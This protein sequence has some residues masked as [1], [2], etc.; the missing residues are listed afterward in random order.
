MKFGG[1]EIGCNHSK[2]PQWG[3]EQGIYVEIK[4]IRLPTHMGGGVGRGLASG[5]AA[6]SSPRG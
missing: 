2:A 6:L 5:M 4:P 1:P 3:A